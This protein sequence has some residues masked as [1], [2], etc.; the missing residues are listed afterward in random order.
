MPKGPENEFKKIVDDYEE[1]IKIMEQSPLFPDNCHPDRT[2]QEHLA[3][4]LEPYV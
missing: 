3:H 4:E 2:L 1:V